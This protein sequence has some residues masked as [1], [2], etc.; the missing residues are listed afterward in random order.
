MNKKVAYIAMIWAIITNTQAQV[1]SRNV[2]DFATAK[3]VDSRIFHN[4][5]I[6]TPTNTM[7]C[8]DFATTKS[9]NDGKIAFLEKVDSSNEA[10]LSSLR[11]LRQQG[12]AKQGEAAASLVIHKSITQ[13]THALESTFES[14]TTKTQKVD[15]SKQA[16]SLNKSQAAGFSKETS[17]NAERYPLFCDDFVGC[18][19]RA[20]GAGIYLSGNEQA[21]RADSRKSAQKPTPN[22]NKLEFI[23]SYTAQ[24]HDGIITG[25]R[26]SVADP[27]TLKA[28]T[29]K[30][31]YTCSLNTPINDLITDDESYAIKYILTHYQEEVLE[32][33]R[34]GRA[35]VR[36]D[37]LTSQNTRVLDST[38][39]AFPPQ[40]I[41]AHL[42]NRY[43]I[44]EVLKE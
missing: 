41:L 31:A 10:F 16:Q 42:D 38:T 44:I 22:T 23:I 29:L 27:I 5:A 12:V 14:L 11:A 43:L 25:E 17:A 8:H 9:R 30:I 3:K 21:H 33:L 13:K 34:K 4:N 39:F 2:A 6:F 28:R 36:H 18:A 1:D 26:Y 24:T 32:C 15:S 35:S 37:G 19:R 20:V 7:D 40:R